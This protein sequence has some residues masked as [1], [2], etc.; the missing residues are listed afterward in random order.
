MTT[1]SSGSPPPSSET[2]DITT[3]HVLS[4]AP[5]VTGGRI[6]FIGIPLD[7]T[8]SELK[9]DL[10]NLITGRPPPE[11]QRLIYRGRA[12]GDGNLSLKTLFQSEVS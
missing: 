3:L 10:Q 8:I 9:K 11:R 2:P 1:P 7:T 12:V 5:E 6:S 4:P